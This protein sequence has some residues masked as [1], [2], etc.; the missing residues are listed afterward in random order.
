VVD[1]ENDT[2]NTLGSL[3]TSVTLTTPDDIGA[4]TAEIVFF[5]PRLRN[6][7]VYL[8]G[9]TVTY[10]EVASL[11]ERVLGRPFKRN[12]WTVPYLLQPLQ[13]DP[14]H[15]INKYRAVFDQGRGVAWPKAGT[16]NAQQSIQ[17]T[18]AEKWARANLSTPSAHVQ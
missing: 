17:V 7:I 8:S 15:H 3:E 9:D 11:L 16:F 12:V 1:C 4:L 14:T 10:A 13:K 5:E 6:Q 18:T 2:V